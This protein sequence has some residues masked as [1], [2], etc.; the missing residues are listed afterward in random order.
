MIAVTRLK[1][2]LRSVNPKL[3]RRD[4]YS[5]SAIKPGLNTEG[6]LS[7]FLT[8]QKVDLKGEYLG[9]SNL[10]KV[11]KPLLTSLRYGIY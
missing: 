9:K 5:Y 7:S 4:L 2:P 10:A 11:D 1:M 8:T 3:D 6:I